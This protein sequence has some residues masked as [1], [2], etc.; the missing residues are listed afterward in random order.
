M[1]ERV[2]KEKRKTD[3]RKNNNPND[4]SGSKRENNTS[5]TAK[6]FTEHS[7]QS[8]QPNE[9]DHD[10]KKQSKSITETQNEIKNNN[11]ISGQPKP[12]KSRETTRRIFRGT[13]RN[14]TEPDKARRNT[15]KT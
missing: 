13:R 10:I 14:K 1:K 9:K 2:S 12:I 5:R 8:E 6:Y 4:K 15:E 7:H 11:K 3:P